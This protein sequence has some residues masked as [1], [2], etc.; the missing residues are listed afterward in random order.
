[1]ALIVQK[2]HFCCQDEREV[3]I[4]WFDTNF[5]NGGD[6]GVKASIKAKDNQEI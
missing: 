1:M 3:K 2:H 4:R 6:G 5:A